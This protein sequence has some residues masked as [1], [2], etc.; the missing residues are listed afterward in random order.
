[1]SDLPVPWGG[2]SS[3]PVAK[4][5]RAKERTELAIYDHQLQADYLRECDLIDTAATF[6]VTKSALESEMR[7]LDEG[8]ALAG[9]SEAKRQ[10]LAE[11]IDLLSRANT[12][13]I[14]RT[15]GG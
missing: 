11:K 4:A 7:L 2:G 1:M 5:A 10:L 15:F 14:S 8:I 3:L 13:R 9:D 6:E 12:A